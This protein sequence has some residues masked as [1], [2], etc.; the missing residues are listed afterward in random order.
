M[1]ELLKDEPLVR[2]AFLLTQ[3]QKEVILVKR[4]IAIIVTV[5]FVFTLTSISFAE[6]KKVE[7]KPKIKEVIGKVKVVDTVAQTITVVNK[8]KAKE[9]V[10][11]KEFDINELRITVDEKTVITMG[12][13]KKELSDVKV[14]N[15]VTVKY[16]EVE[17][18]NVAES[19][20]IMSVKKAKTA[21][22]MKQYLS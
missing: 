20:A 9:L 8:I 21:K 7:E 18:K 12:E 10:V 2:F 1:A 5:L 16:A 22:K 17:G 14:G 11:G 3:Q 6:E 13:K 19:V 15:K 4:A